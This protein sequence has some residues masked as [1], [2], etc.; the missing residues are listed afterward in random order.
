M[1]EEDWFDS[2]LA[3]KD[4]GAHEIMCAPRVDHNTTRALRIKSLQSKGTPFRIRISKQ[5]TFAIIQ[6]INGIYDA[7]IFKFFKLILIRI[8]LNPRRRNKRGSYRHLSHNKMVLPCD[9]E[10]V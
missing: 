3:R 1:T 2:S 6:S 5:V 4:R 8:Y 7:Y 9:Q 10:I